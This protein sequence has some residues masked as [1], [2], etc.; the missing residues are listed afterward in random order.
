MKSNPNTA[1]LLQ[2]ALRKE[3]AQNM[4]NEKGPSTK[5]KGGVGGGAGKVH[6]S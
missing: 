6:L 5:S 1:I 4:K 2:N 3:E